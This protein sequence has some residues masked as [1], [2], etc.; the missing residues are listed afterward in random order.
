MPCVAQDITT[1]ESFAP[2]RAEARARGY[3]SAAAI[4]LCNGATRIGVLSLYAIER[5]AFD[6]DE[7]ALLEEIAVD[8]VLAVVRKTTSVW[9]SVGSWPRRRFPRGGSGACNPR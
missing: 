3:A 1:D 5:D 9:R 6:D 4:P 8:L 2:W 7:V